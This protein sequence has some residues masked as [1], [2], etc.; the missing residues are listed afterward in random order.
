MKTYILRC[1]DCGMKLAEEKELLDIVG[2]T[3]TCDGPH[4]DV[5]QFIGQI[6]DI[7]TEDDSKPIYY[8]KLVRDRIPE[9]IEA[10]GCD[11]EFHVAEQDDIGLLL[12]NKL[13]EEVHE[14]NA[15]SCVEELADILEIIDA[16]RK[17]HGFTL[18]EIKLAKSTKRASRGG[19]DKML[20]LDSTLKRPVLTID[21]SHVHLN[22]GNTEKLDKDFKTSGTK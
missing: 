19:F 17:Y 14:F 6:K 5:I 2:V 8:G 21:G 10:D 4:D 12:E 20:V 1:P 16:V 15:K 3:F 18:N 22:M 7:H 9:I 11:C 13:L